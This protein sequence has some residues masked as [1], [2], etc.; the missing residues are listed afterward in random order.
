MEIKTKFAKKVKNII[1]YTK[2]N[3]YTKHIT[4]DQLKEETRM[5]NY[6]QGCSLQC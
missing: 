1:E 3:E 2:R 6:S 5:K 4:Q